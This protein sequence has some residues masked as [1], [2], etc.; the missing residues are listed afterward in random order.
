MS[1][2]VRSNDV[3]ADAF[4]NISVIIVTLLVLN[5]EMFKDV[6]L[7][8]CENMPYMSVTLLVSKLVKS[9]VVKL[10]DSENI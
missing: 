3:N 1:K 5:V 2:L 9:K 10:D 7:V 6:R 4:L 8:V